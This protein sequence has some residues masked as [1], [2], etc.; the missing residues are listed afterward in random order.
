MNLARVHPWII[1]RI[2]ITGSGVHEKVREF[3]R[4]SYLALRK[5][6]VF[7]DACV[8]VFSSLKA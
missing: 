2:C 3:F 5:F 6:I 8:V 7:L 4:I 1:A